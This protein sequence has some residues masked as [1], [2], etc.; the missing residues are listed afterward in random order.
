MMGE[1]RRKQIGLFRYGLI[2]PVLSGNVNVQIDYF[3][4][5]A[6][7]EY[8]V[9]YTGMRKYKARTFKSWL[10]RYRTGGF[11][12]LM[13]KNRGDKGK[14]RKIDDHLAD[15]IKETVL[16]FPV[17][18]CAAIY[19]MLIAEGKIRSDGVTEATVR[20]YISD[21]EL[22]QK[23]VPEPRKKFEKEHVNDLW[24]ADC[25]HGPYIPCGKKKHK[26]L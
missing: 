22:K 4:D 13:P 10:K 23:S 7:K 9:P 18:S 19:R 21:N 24:I 15:F 12:A 14:S 26:E 16:K 25:M 1:D 20:N 6:E 17:V 5:A 11:D 3:R 2:A 8:D